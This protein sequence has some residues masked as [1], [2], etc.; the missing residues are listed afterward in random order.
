MSESDATPPIRVLVCDDQALVRTGYVTIFSAQPDMEVVGEAEN[1]HEA[2]Q[3]TRRLRPDV[4]VMD[5]RMPCSTAS[6]PPAN[7]L[8]PMPR[9]RRRCWS[10]PPSTSTR[11]CTTP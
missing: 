9:I 7:W 2:V 11:T 5:I 10:S 1:G 4:V 6:R 8:A 3:A